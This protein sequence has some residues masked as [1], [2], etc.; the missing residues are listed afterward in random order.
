MDSDGYTLD[1]SRRKIKDDYPLP[2]TI[3]QYKEKDKKGNSKNDKK[4]KHFYVSLKEIEENDL[5]LNYNLYK[6]FV[7]EEYNYEPPKNLV[8]KLIKLEEK[9]NEGLSTLKTS[10]Q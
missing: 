5:E 4:S 9:I 6:E 1:N 8:E 7:F 2:E 10:F 3:K